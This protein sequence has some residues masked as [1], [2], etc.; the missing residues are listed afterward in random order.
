VLRASGTNR[1]S[2]AELWETAAVNE[3]RHDF[4][5]TGEERRGDNETTVSVIQHAAR[6]IGSV[7]KL[8]VVLD[9]EL[10][11]PVV[12]WY[13]TACGLGADTITVL[14]D[15]DNS[16][17]VVGFVNLLDDVTNETATDDHPSAQARRT[18]DFK[19]AL[20]TGCFWFP[21]TTARGNISRASR[22]IETHV[23]FVFANWCSA[24]K[25]HLGWT[26]EG[27][28]TATTPLSTQ[29]WKTKLRLLMSTIQTTTVHSERV[30]SKRWRTTLSL[31]FVVVW[32]VD[33]LSLRF[34]FS[35]SGPLVNSF[36][37]A[38]LDNNIGTPWPRT[39]ISWLKRFQVIF[40]GWSLAHVFPVSSSS[41][42]PFSFLISANYLLPTETRKPEKH[43]KRRLD[44][45]A[46]WRTSLVSGDLGI[47][48]ERHPL[49]RCN[50]RG[51][52]A[53]CWISGSLTITIRC[54]QGEPSVGSSVTRKLVH[55]FFA[56]SAGLRQL[57]M[58]VNK[59]RLSRTT[60]LTSVLNAWSKDTL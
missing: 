57:F 25:L 53:S 45:C 33:T 30:V 32:L 6:G 60:V 9:G 48:V 20:S 29:P 50:Q 39:F 56:L 19:K 28:K 4:F 31:C 55:G 24:W 34:V 2:E 3:W 44:V 23:D 42:K 49:R 14:P 54:D 13:S 15:A 35:V 10:M 7:G 12:G 46:S 17:V 51:M 37:L 38:P 22:F 47:I 41:W 36:V 43:P 21:R 52:T 16:F 8:C 26:H 5:C 18:F 40:L 58:E 59:K 11:M 27:D 1:F